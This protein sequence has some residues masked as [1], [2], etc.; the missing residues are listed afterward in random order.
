VF[1]KDLAKGNKVG[2]QEITFRQA[3]ILKSIKKK[4]DYLICYNVKIK[5]EGRD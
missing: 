2:V 3:E 4:T 5:F 1:K